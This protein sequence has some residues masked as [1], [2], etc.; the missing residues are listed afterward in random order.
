MTPGQTFTVI[1]AFLFFWGAY[2][3]ARYG[4]VPYFAIMT[5][6][7]WLGIGAGWLAK[8]IMEVWQ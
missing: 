3:T 5:G 1:L 6:A 8:I 2:T 7:L 4:M